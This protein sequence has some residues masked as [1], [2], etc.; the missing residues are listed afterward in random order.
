[1]LDLLAAFPKRSFTLSEISRGAKMNVASCHAVLNVLAERG[2]LTRDG[3]SYSLGRSLVALG[4]AALKGAP[5]VG[6]ASEAAEELLGD[7]GTP[8]LLTTVVGEEI[9]AIVSLQIA[10]RSAGMRAGE[11]RPFA[12]PLGAPFMAWAAE[13]EVEAWIG[14]HSS[15]KD[16][17]LPR[18][19]RHM[20]ALT[21]QRGYQV[22]LST[23]K[24]PEFAAIMDELA[25]GRRGGDKQEVFRL[26]NAL[27]HELTQ[28]EII[29]PDALYDVVLIS[30]PVFD[31]NGRAAFALCLGGFDEKLT[32]AEITSHAD[33][34]LRTCIDIVRA[35][36]NEP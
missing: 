2:Y 18:E 27:E 16:E 22:V 4:S 21:R 29:E 24:S 7:L 20:L 13:A 3:R 32:G 15:P 11:R 6:R 19:W 33:R 26:F 35:D 17:Q 30:S 9:V 25:T 23:P 36:R 8:V 12:A 28:P 14:R 10:D 5:L 1:V 31:K 34:L